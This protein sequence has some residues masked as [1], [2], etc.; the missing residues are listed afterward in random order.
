M[1]EQIVINLYDEPE[2]DKKVYYDA[3]EGILFLIDATQSMLHKD[4]NCNHS[5]IDECLKVYKNIMAQKMSWNKAD[6]MGI[7]LFGSSKSDPELQQKSIFV[8]K[9]F[10]KISID[11]FKEIE[12]CDIS[13]YIGSGS[14]YPLHDALWNATLMIDKAKKS[15]YISK[16]ILLTCQDNPLATD[17]SERHRIRLKAAS[18]HDVGVK[19]N[20]VGLGKTWN[21]DL[22]YKEL[23]M[24]AGSL[25]DDEYNRICIEDLEECIV[26][27]SKAVSTLPWRIGSLEISVSIRSVSTK[28]KYPKQVKMNKADN[29]ILQSSTYFAPMSFHSD[30]DDDDDDTIV[31]NYTSSDVFKY[32]EY[33]QQKIVFS[34][35]ELRELEST[36]NKRI[37]LICFKPLKID[38]IHHLS[39]PKYI[40]CR[41][42]LKDKKL[43]F[44][45]IL[46]K[47]HSKNLMAICSV[48]QRQGGKLNLFSLIPNI[49]NGGFYMWQ[50]PFLEHVRDLN[51]HLANFIYNDPPFP[52]DEDGKSIWQDILKKAFQNRDTLL[53]QNPKLQ[54]LLANIEA[55]ALDRED[56]KKPK[57]ETLVPDDEWYKKNVKQMIDELKDIY[58]LEEAA[59]KRKK[60]QSTAQPKK[61]TKAG[62]T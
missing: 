53:C 1:S 44:A 50:I 2:N 41:E 3:R 31:D 6:Y 21:P 38:P 46:N 54:V 51:E 45:S 10:E 34:A 49:E 13:E 58:P 39:A 9:K 25:S 19:L 26:R 11:H 55:L 7:I 17:Q 52:V 18:Y 14:D 37:E 30:D 61:V 42:K 5:Y 16:V 22:F 48:V 36:G 24:L 56:P 20:V 23:E 4:P 59:S 12:N 33:G 8:L 47:C 40:T 35:L 28:P 62:K 29:E 57:D 32:Q 43:V 15:I 27:P 60:K